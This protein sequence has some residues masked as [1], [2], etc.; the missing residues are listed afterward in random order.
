MNHLFD[1]YWVTLR[2]YFLYN[3]SFLTPW[4][5]FAPFSFGEQEERLSV[6]V[7][8]RFSRVE[9]ILF[10]FSRIF[11]SLKSM[12]CENLNF[13]HHSQ[14]TNHFWPNFQLFLS[15]NPMRQTFSLWIVKTYFQS[16]LM[17][18]FLESNETC[19]FMIQNENPFIWSQFHFSVF[20]RIFIARAWFWLF[21][22][23]GQVCEFMHFFNSDSH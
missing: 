18:Y 8:L 16:N 9:R 6:R 20:G 17:K 1:E 7:F 10:K 21:G 23:F 5:S 12:K 4:A 13:S 19:F 2:L 11:I 14:K 15:S 3:P 22:P